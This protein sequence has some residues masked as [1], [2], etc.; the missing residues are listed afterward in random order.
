MNQIQSQ[1]DRLGEP[2]I[3]SGVIE[4]YKYV[5]VPLV[6]KPSKQNIQYGGFQPYPFHTSLFPHHYEGKNNIE[7]ERFNKMISN[8]LFEKLVG[9]TVVNKAI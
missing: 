8:I 7:D 9:V 2:K 1:K 4:E 6:L 3:E 5:I